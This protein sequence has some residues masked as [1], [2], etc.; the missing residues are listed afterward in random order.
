[1]IKDMARLGLAT[2]ARFL[3]TD[4]FLSA[5]KLILFAGDKHRWTQTPILSQTNAKSLLCFVNGTHREMLVGS[6]STSR[7][8]RGRGS[9]SFTLMN[10]I[11]EEGDEIVVLRLNATVLFRGI[12]DRL[13][14]THAIQ[15]AGCTEL[16]TQVQA[17][18]AG[19]LLAR[20]L[21]FGIFRPDYFPTIGSILDVLFAR[22]F[23]DLELSYDTAHASTPLEEEI[24][25][26]WVP[27]DKALDALAA[28][29]GCFWSVTED[30]VRFFNPLT[31][32][33]SGSA[34][35]LES[36]PNYQQITISKSR[37]N[38]ANRVIARPSKLFRMGILESRI[39]I[40]AAT[41]VKLK[42]PLD[43]NPKRADLYLT[44]S[45]PFPTA[46]EISDGYDPA[47]PL[48][49]Q[50]GSP[51]IYVTSGSLTGFL[52]IQYVTRF[53]S[54]VD[55]RDEDRIADEGELCRVID[56]NG[57]TEEAVEA[58]AQAVFDLAAVVP[59]A[60]TVRTQVENYDVGQKIAVDVPSLD[61]DEDF[62]VTAVR[63]S[64]TASPE[65]LQGEI[66]LSNRETLRSEFAQRL[67][68][69]QESKIPDLPSPSKWDIKT[70]DT[71]GSQ[72]GSVK[73]TKRSILL[74]IHFYT[75]YEAGAGEP[76]GIS[77]NLL[78]N[79]VVFGGFTIETWRA[80]HN[81][82]W[83]GTFSQSVFESGDEITVM[84][85]D[86]QGNVFGA[87]LE[88]YLL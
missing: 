37:T 63:Y 26:F 19:A 32:Y 65:V 45:D 28:R 88:L 33:I 21:V 11:P 18:D 69:K 54:I 78:V 87:T 30:V 7:A 23:A 85:D 43:S 84:L 41:V 29:L 77:V 5:D 80:R 6:F 86:N 73:V 9:A 44:L 49:F 74:A 71:A 13:S 34:D 62:V 58:D 24:D 40:T 48:Y 82:N 27:G 53:A 1:M 46:M 81:D 51:F 10:Y 35:I 14:A 25:F 31:G 68:D 3:P 47:Y 66:A 12:I 70:T 67:F 57:E 8:L 76:D 15:Q 20:R 22:E 59:I 4:G 75:H 17:I 50:V 56:S 60:A 79:G 2:E 38:Y 39:P 52:R 55:I 83:Y 61:V 64:E 36:D 16:R 72:V 42:F